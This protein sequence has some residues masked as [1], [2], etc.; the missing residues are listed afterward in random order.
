VCRNR[1]YGRWRSYRQFLLGLDC[2]RF[3]LMVMA[4]VNELLEGGFVAYCLGS[5]GIGWG[6]SFLFT[7][8]KKMGEKI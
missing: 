7:S 4:H 3:S 1:L 5:F 6:I 8:A 2:R